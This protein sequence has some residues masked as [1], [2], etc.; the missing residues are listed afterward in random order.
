M[1]VASKQQALAYV[2]FEISDIFEIVDELE[3]ENKCLRGLS[4]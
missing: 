4:R 2:L 1:R 3:H